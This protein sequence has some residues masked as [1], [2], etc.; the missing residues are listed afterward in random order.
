MKLIFKTTQLFLAA[1]I[2]LS[3]IVFQPVISYAL[4]EEEELLV[5]IDEKAAFLERHCFGTLFDYDYDFSIQL[6]E[7]ESDWPYYQVRFLKSAY[8]SD[9]E[10]LSYEKVKKQFLER[11]T[12]LG[13]MLCVPDSILNINGVAYVKYRE[14][15]TFGESGFKIHDLK[16]IEINEDTVYTHSRSFFADGSLFQ[17][18]DILLQKVNGSWNISWISHAFG[19][20]PS[21]TT[22][23]IEAVF[24]DYIE[25]T[26]LSYI[27]SENINCGYEK[28]S[29]EVDTWGKTPMEIIVESFD[30][31]DCT[32]KAHAIIDEYD[33]NG[34]VIS[35]H[36]IT[37]EIG[38]NLSETVTDYDLTN[39][40]P[41]TADI[42]CVFIVLAVIF[43]TAGLF[44]LKKKPN[45]TM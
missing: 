10:H 5:L 28:F 8:Q 15:Y 12:P 23:Q 19:L 11:T 33:E 41:H 37:V 29:Q 35:Q 40:N 25:Q 42:T 43:G 27:V 45:L 34:K 1:A 2:L 39:G 9:K 16:I 18:Y 21:A 17:E 4:T 36:K 26:I 7:A 44:L 24:S 6:E 20:D 14:G 30:A 32:G 13:F 31:E 3:S 22:E 38:E